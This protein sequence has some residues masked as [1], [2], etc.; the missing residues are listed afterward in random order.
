[1]LVAWLLARSGRR[2]AAI[3]ALRAAAVAMP[4]GHLVAYS[5]LRTRVHWPTGVAGGMLL[6]ILVAL[7]LKA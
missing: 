3:L 5:R 2:K 7:A 4:L 1:M 6:G